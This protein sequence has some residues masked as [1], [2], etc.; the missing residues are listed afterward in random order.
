MTNNAAGLTDAELEQWANT[1]ADDAG[2]LARELLACRR[3][4]PQP[5]EPVAPD[6]VALTDEQIIS[7]LDGRQ[8]V[9]AHHGAAVFEYRLFPLID[10]ARRV[11]ALATLPTA[12]PA[13]PPIAGEPVAPDEIPLGMAGWL[14]LNKPLHPLTVNLVVRF[15]RALASKLSDAEAKYG[16]SDGWRSNDW[17]D[18][19]RAQLLE[20][21]AKGDPRDVAAY[22]AFLW[23]HG[24]KTS[25]TAPQPA[26]TAPDAQPAVTQ[27][28]AT[29]ER[30]A[31][32]HRLWL[33]GGGNPD[34][35]EGE[36]SEENVAD[37]LHGLSK[38]ADKPEQS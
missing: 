12:P 9:R 26:Q 28:G 29:M 3:A 7:C 22:C 6:A 24:E 21:V 17:L 13:Q 20:H 32:L 31:L 11:L 8:P 2:R 27:A 35:K 14:T 4:A 10:F 5:A 15:A 16:Y 19:C 25:G 30:Q 1:R 37:L 34:L 33:E 18:E 38:L 36:V 23:H